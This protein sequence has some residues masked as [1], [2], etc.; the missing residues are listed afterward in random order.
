MPGMPDNF[1]E[2]GQDL[3]DQLNYAETKFSQGFI[4]LVPV[5]VLKRGRGNSIIKDISIRKFGDT[6]MKSV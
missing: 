2:P 5:S 6:Q 4:N 3:Q 1:L